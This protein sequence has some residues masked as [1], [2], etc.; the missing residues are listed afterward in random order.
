MGER[1]G[2]YMRVL[3]LALISILLAACGAAGGTAGV[4]QTSGSLTVRVLQPEDGATV[5]SDTVTVK[6]EAPAETV[7]T[8]NDDILVVGS[9]EKFETNVLLDEGP[10]VIEI[11][12]S[13]LESNEVDFEI[14]VTYE[15]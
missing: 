3:P 15:P 4:A 13:D 1:L 9:D 12:A 8:V 10:N 2:K 6:G 5:H 11:V 14:S 7:V